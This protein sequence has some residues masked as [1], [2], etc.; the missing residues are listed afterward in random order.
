MQEDKQPDTATETF[1]GQDAPVPTPGVEQAPPAKP[2]FKINLF[3]TARV[4]TEQF[5]ESFD[6]RAAAEEF[7]RE[8]CKDKGIDPDFEIEEVPV[9][10]VDVSEDAEAESENNSEGSDEKTTPENSLPVN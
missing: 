1:E 4:H 9:P 10:T 8:Q 6:D 7:A 5:V 2:V 3:Q